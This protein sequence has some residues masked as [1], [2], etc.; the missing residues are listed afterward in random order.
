MKPSLNQTVDRLTTPPI[1]EIQNWAKAYDGR[2]GPLID[3]S[4]AVPG[5][6]PPP[7]M[8]QLLSEAGGSTSSTGYGFIEGEPAL[9]DA[10]A[11][12]VSSFYN[13]T[14]R[15][16]QTHITSGCNQAFIATAMAIAGAGETVLMTNPCYFN[17]ETTLGMLG[18]QTAKVDCD[19]ENNF[20]PDIE[21]IRASL[22]NA[23]A[24]A[25]VSP[26]NPTGTVY[27][28]ELLA[29]I[30]KACGDAGVWLIVDETYRDFIQD[31]FKHDLLSKPDWADNLILLYSFSKSFC[32]PGHRLGAII[33][34][35]HVIKA[36]AKVM[37]NIQICAPR[38]AQIAV[39]EAIEPLA[40]WR[41]DNR[42]E[43]TR[44][45]VVMRDEF[46]SLANWDIS[47]MG[48]YF[49]YVRHPYKDM[50]SIEAAKN[51]VQESGISS[52]PGAFFG[53]GQEEY[54]R[55]AFANVDVDTIRTLGNRLS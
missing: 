51:L 8:L 42:E 12:H 23:K 27:P 13:T 40:G 29:Q 9:R 39:A 33:A 11:E 2:C 49:A 6:P 15:A 55:F 37:D 32:I 30:L 16:S 50:T 21:A 4:Q 44:R 46:S 26:N 17:H 22:K 7:E 53:E 38:A 43:I 28:P 19:P 1:P 25:L 31:E 52:V 34:A 45:S 48:A 36:V 35:D 41:A 54:L 20:L 10:Y 14:I 3:L 5:Y 24:L 47:S 18:I